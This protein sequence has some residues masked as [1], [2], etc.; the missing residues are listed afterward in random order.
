MTNAYTATSGSISTTVSGSGY[1]V[2]VYPGQIDSSKCYISLTGTPTVE[3]SVAYTFPISFVDIYDNLHYQSLSDEI[4][5]GMVVSVTADYV[6]HNN[7]P[8]PIGIADLANWQ[9]TYGTSITGS[10]SDSSDG[11]MAASV[12]IQRAGSYSIT[13][14]VDGTEVIG[15]TF[16]S[17]DFQPTTLNAAKCEVLSVPSQIM[18]GFDYSF[19]IQGRD[20]YSNNLVKTLSAAIGSNKSSEMSLSTNS[21]VTYSASI[22][23]DTSAGVYR[24]EYSV[25]TT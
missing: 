14:I 20:Q 22:V 24:V 8:S 17:V 5:G 23:D 21:G 2:T 15:S 3:A 19:K 10:A 16:S 13:A 18:A 7:Y 12:T 1:T 11:T 9:T 6:D 25:P 4:S